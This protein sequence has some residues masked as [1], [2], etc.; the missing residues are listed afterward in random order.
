M[1]E[2]AELNGS[3]VAVGS[4]YLTLQSV[5]STLIGVFGY[6]Y[7][8]RAITREEMGVIAGVTL[9][10]SLIQTVVD[11]GINSSIAKYVVA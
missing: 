7:M 3:K 9:L 4:I 10:C 8:S 1:N 11:L 5:L 2:K 6:A